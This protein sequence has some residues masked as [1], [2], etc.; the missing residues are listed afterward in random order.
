MNEDET[1]LLG[2][3][4]NG[5]VDAFAELFESLRSRVFAVALRVVG[6]DD[7]DDVVMETYLKAWQAIPRF[8]RRSSLTTRRL[9]GTSACCWTC[10]SKPAPVSQRDNLDDGERGKLSSLRQ[11]VV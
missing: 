7:A 1:I 3:A 4:Q 10:T 8:N 5:D 2:K 6:P 9:G 11:V